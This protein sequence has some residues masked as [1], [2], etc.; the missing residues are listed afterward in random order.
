MAE[1]VKEQKKWKKQ[2][3]FDKV[4][5]YLDDLKTALIPHVKGVAAEDVDTDEAGAGPD[6]H[7]ASSSG[8]LRLPYL[9]WVNNDVA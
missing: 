1:I 7:S 4:R 5:K 9:D 2:V 6:T 8:V 3:R